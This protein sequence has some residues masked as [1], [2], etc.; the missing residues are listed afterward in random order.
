MRNLIIGNT[1]QLS[2]FFP[3]DNFLSISS[4]NIDL[5]ALKNEKFDSIFLTFAEQR[6]FLKENLDFFTSINVKYTLNL[7]NELWDNTERFVVYSTSELWNNCEG[8]INLDVEY[9][10]NYSHYIRSKEILCE[11]IRDDK[12]LREKIIIVYP[13]NFNSSFRKE[14]FMFSKIY[15][16]LREKKIVNIGNVD[17]QRDLIHPSIVVEKSLYCDSDVIV[18]SGELINVKKFI[19]DIFNALNLD[20]DNFINFLDEDFLKI[21]RKEHFSGISS[22]DYQILLDLTVKDIKNNLK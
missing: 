13:F 2:Y 14:G 1:S 17:F 8:P 19:H 20:I 5:N 11:N 9:N 16:S 7:I 12:D 4:R 18:G 15:E 3:K 21:R 22:C 10:Y 6:T